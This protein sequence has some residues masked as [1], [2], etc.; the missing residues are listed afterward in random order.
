MESLIKNKKEKVMK[1]FFPAG[2]K[3]SQLF[4]YRR[5]ASLANT[6]LGKLQRKCYRAQIATGK[7]HCLYHYYENT[8]KGK[9]GRIKIITGD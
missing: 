4:R 6:P 2:Y 1:S 7:R 8:P 5:V 3:P 9:V